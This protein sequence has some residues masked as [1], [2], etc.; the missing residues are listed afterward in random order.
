MRLLTLAVPVALAACAQGVS[1]D[2][3]IDYVSYDAGPARGAALPDSATPSEPPVAYPAPYPDHS[4]PWFLDASGSTSDAGG[5]QAVTPRPVDSGTPS[6]MAALDAA[7]D[8]ST[9]SRDAANDNSTPARDAAAETSTVVDAGAPGAGSGPMCS[10]T[11][12][13]P[14]ATTCGACTCTKCAAQ[15]AS[16][17][18]SNDTAKNTHCAAVQACAEQNHCVGSACYCGDSPLCLNPN[19]K[20]RA[21]IE[22]AAGTTNKF[23][24]QRAGDDTN[25]ALGRA[26][27][28]GN[29]EL[30]SCRTECSL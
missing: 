24:I 10:A 29:C 6:S 25:T 9:L 15:V 20:C 27:A 22:A 4:V 12:A 21:I 3:E 14:T 16:C 26:K 11:P 19:G 8:T 23:D 2:E 1:L 13:Y 7:A 30:S 28:I 18:A 17:Y 5:T